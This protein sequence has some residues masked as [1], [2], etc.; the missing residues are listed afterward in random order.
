[1]T[2]MKASRLQLSL[3]LPTWHDANDRMTPWAELRTVA[4]LAEEAGWDTLWVADHFAP[5]MPDGSIQHFWECWAVLG[6]LAEATSRIT[7]G[8]LITPT[9]FRNPAL[10]ARMAATLDEISD[11][12]L[13]LGLGAGAEREQGFAL[14]GLPRE[15][16]GSMFAEALQVLVPLLREGHV[17]FAGRFYSVSDY[18]LNA[19]RRRNSPP[20]WIA[21]RGPRMIQLAARWGD[22]FNLNRTLVAPEEAAA[23][24]AQ[25]DAAC[26]E[27]GREPATILRTGYVMITLTTSGP[28]SAV[29][30]TP[31]EIAAR[32]HTFHTAGIQHLTCFIDIGGPSSPPN[33]LPLL[34]PQAIE[35]F[36]PVMAALRRLEE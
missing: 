33:S 8:P 35:R 27:M 14:L 30:G 11:G 16:R 17:D 2:A 6:A 3:Y 21:G 4:R 23:P 7:L 34:T 12:R 22:A 24:L 13:L 15:Q 10:L 18:S 28:R 26:R 32:L 29:H 31:D 25:L 19:P 36:A 20:I 5:R 9:A 1:M